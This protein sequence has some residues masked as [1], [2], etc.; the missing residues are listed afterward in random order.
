ML[1]FLVEGLSPDF[2]PYARGL[3]LQERERIRVAEQGGP[4]SLILL[5]HE[6]VFTAGRRTQPEERPVDTAT[7]IYEVDRGGKISWH[8]PGQLTGYPILRLRNQR[9][10]VG[11]VRF[12]ESVMIDVIDGF[13]IQGFR[14]EGRSGV[15]TCLLYTSPSPRD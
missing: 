3:E 11:Y 6:P 5:E 12:L 7:P 13:G 10:L 2:V 14:V 1:D 15:W 9:D 4:G 8:G